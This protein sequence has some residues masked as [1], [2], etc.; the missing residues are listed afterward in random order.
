M[1][2]ENCLCGEDIG[3]IHTGDETADKCVF[4]FVIGKD[5]PALL[6][7]GKM[8]PGGCHNFIIGILGKGITEQLIIVCCGHRDGRNG[9]STS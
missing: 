2:A 1:Q 6:L 3:I 9:D 8:K 7:A 4:Q 5:R